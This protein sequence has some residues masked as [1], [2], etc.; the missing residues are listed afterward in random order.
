MKKLI[1]VLAT[2]AF[3]MAMSTSVYAHCG[4]CGTGA[5]K[6]LKKDCAAKCKASKDKE[7]MTKCAADHKKEHKKK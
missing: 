2:V 6:V 1:S 4:G 5:E 3:A 7:C